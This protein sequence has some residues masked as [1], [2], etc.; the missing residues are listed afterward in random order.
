[1]STADLRPEVGE[2]V[3]I[4]DG[5]ERLRGLTGEVLQ[6]RGQ[7]YLLVR[8]TAVRQAVKVQVPADWVQTEA[9]A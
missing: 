3:T 5:P 6:H 4:T 7:T 8:V 2:T 1:L 9:T